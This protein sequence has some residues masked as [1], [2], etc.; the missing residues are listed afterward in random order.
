ML[1]HSKAKPIKTNF[2]LLA[3]FAVI[4]IL[5]LFML[6][7]V[8]AVWN[9]KYLARAAS[10]NSSLTYLGY[11]ITGY[12]KTHHGQVPPNLRALILMIGFEDRGVLMCPL[13]YDHVY[14]YHCVKN[15]GPNDPIA[16]DYG[17]H[18]PMH[19]LL[20]F[21]NRPNRNVLY[22]DGRVVNMPEEAFQKLHL[23]G[24]SLTFEQL[25]QIES[26]H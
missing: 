20:R 6:S 12:R 10:C 8:D 2:A 22:A 14:T 23:S 15:P 5:G 21:L 19:S 13:S 1:K 11:E 18:V 7:F 3:V 4:L 26:K 16:W 24:E 9:S 25:D 17:P